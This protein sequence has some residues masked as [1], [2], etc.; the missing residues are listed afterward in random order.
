M[1]N[2][3]MDPCYNSLG[4]TI[5]FDERLDLLGMDLPEFEAE[6]A[7]FGQPRFRARQVFEWL[8]RSLTMDFQR[9]GN[10]PQPLRALL[11]SMFGTPGLS[12]L[13]EQTSSDGLTTKVLFALWDGE[14]VESVLMHQREPAGER[15]SVCVSTQIGCP[16]GCAFCATGQSGF[17]RNLGAGEIVGQ[18]L[19]FA[20]MLAAQGIERP[21]SNVVFMGQGEPLL[22]REATRRAVEILNAPEGFNLGARH[23]TISTAGVVPGIRDLAR[24]PLQVGLA[25]SLHAPDDVLRSR[26][27]P[28]NRRYPLAPTLDACMEY[29]EKTGRRVTFE[30]AMIERLNDSPAQ[31]R[32]LANLLHGQLGHVNLIPLNATPD[33]PYQPSPRG[34]VLAFQAELQAKGIPTTVRVERG[35]DID[36]ACG[37]L[38]RRH[39]N[40]PDGSRAQNPG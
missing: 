40:Q 38:R 32:Q 9:M 10:L 35:A 21:V 11:D 25:V 2:T 12:P 3:K 19:Y 39:A 36:A 29:S 15:R 37:Q 5:V 22:N 28:L 14:S 17:V 31:A 16:V 24:W 6:L 33:S 30:Y 26:L 34:R 8:Y 7:A 4:V 1:P 27:V 23:M 18:V 20:A 13:A